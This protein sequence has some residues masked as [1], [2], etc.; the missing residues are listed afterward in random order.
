MSPFDTKQNKVAFKDN[1]NYPQKLFLYHIWQNFQGGKFSR[2]QD[3]TPFTGKVLRS[4][5][6]LG[7]ITGS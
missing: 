7:Y 3:K 1:K 6:S 4:E 5:A 2:L